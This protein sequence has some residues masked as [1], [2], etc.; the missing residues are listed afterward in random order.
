MINKPAVFSLKQNTAFYL[1]ICRYTQ[2][3]MSILQTVL[4][5]IFRGGGGVVGAQKSI[6]H[7]ATFQLSWWRKTSDALLCITSDT[8]GHLSRTIDVV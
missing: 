5:V 7:M 4:Q 1:M 6:C 2:M 8:N 3:Y